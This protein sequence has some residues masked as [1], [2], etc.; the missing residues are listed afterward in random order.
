MSDTCDSFITGILFDIQAAN[1]AVESTSK[2]ER[3]GFYPDKELLAALMENQYRRGLPRSRG[4]LA[5]D[6]KGEQN[7]LPAKRQKTGRKAHL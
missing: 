3:V 5:R 6:T 1:E 7:S 2:S 4:N